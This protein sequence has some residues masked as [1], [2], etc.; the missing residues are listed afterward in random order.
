MTD[1]LPILPAHI[2]TTVEAIARLHDEHRRGATA[3]QRLVD[4]LTASIGRPRFVVLL[5]VTVLAW[6]SGNLLARASLHIAWDNPPFNWLQGAVTLLAL[7]VA[8]LILSTQRRDDQLA[9][10]REQLTLELAI[11][12]EQKAAK[13]IALLEEMR[14]DNPNLRNRIDVEAEAMSVPSDP[15]TVLEAL[16]DLDLSEADDLPLVAPPLESGT[17]ESR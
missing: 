8:V 14:R 5:T 9:S 6:T 17:P 3:I 12:G 4:R 11:L 1:E 10:Y 7:Y 16:K 13:I 2:Q 15:Q